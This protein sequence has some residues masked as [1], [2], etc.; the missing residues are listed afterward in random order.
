MSGCAGSD[1]FGV[2]GLIV[3]GQDDGMKYFN[4][5]TYGLMVI[6]VALA[7]AIAAVYWMPNPAAEAGA[8]AVRLNTP[9]SHRLKTADHAVE[10]TSFDVYEQ[11]FAQRDVFQAFRGFSA[12]NADKALRDESSVS[13]GV[14]EERVKIVAILVDQS[15]RAVVRD[16]V[17]QETVF[18]SV[19]DRFSGAVV[20][21]ILPG[22]VVFNRNGQAVTLS[23]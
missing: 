7:G 10:P 23:P 16:L 19:G 5:M 2:F 18:L 6:C 15:P 9:E 13:G 4:A 17:S 20:T 3:A 22:K 11:V 1:I 14:L 8:T 21:G 12:S